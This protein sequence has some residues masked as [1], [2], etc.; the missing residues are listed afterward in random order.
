VLKFCLAA[1]FVAVVVP[2]VV[3]AS[4]ASAIGFFAFVAIVVGV[5]LV[6]SIPLAIWEVA[7]HALGHG[8]EDVDVR[9]AERDERHSR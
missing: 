9:V 5:L 1:A 3:I 2:Q 8:A 4:L 6:L 7:K